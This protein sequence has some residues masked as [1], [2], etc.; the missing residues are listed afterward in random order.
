[1]VPVNQ[2]LRSAPNVPHLNR[3]IATKPSP[4]N[5]APVAAEPGPSFLALFSGNYKSPTAAPTTPVAPATPAAST[6]PAVPG[7]QRG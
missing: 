5:A 1:M 2:S 7:P 6:P 3:V 4:K